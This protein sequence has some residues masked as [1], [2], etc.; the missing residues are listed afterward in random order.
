MR[1]YE[2]PGTGWRTNT[3]RKPM[4]RLSNRILLLCGF[5]VGTQVSV[6]YEKDTVTITRLR[7]TYANYNESTTT[8]TVTN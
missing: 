3:V 6:R 8:G 1:V 4:V 5:T 7:H 2:A